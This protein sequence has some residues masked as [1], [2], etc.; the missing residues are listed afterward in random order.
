VANSGNPYLWSGRGALRK[1]GAAISLTGG[2]AVEFH[3]IATNTGAVQRKSLHFVE[4]TKGNPNFTLVFWSLTA[5]GVAKD[6][7]P[8]HLLQGLEQGGS[9]TVNGESLGVGTSISVAFSEA[10][11]AL[12]S[13][14]LYWNRASFPLEVHA[15]AAYRFA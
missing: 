2:N 6:F 5:T 14:D 3:R 9:I 13:V 4:I 10:A 1:T 7:S 15:L 11:G 8:A 12:D